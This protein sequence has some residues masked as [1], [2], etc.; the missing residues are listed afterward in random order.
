MMSCFS[1]IIPSQPSTIHRVVVAVV[2]VDEA[3]FGAV[4]FAGLLDG[5]GD[6]SLRCDFAVGGVCVG[7]T[8]VAMLAVDFA[9][10]F[11]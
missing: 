10:I 5:L 1:K 8:D 3:Q 6:I 2:V 4:V 7:G 9:D 11:R